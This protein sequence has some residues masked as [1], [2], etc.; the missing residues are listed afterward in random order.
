[1]KRRAELLFPLLKSKQTKQMRAGKL[2]NNRET[3]PETASAL[4]LESRQNEK[5]SN[6]SKKPV[7]AES[8]KFRVE[9]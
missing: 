3:E 4:M 5:V 7:K 6:N 1:V 8:Q 9:V 2:G